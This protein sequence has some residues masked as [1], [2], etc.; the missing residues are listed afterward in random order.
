MGICK[1]VSTYSSHHEWV[2][3]IFSLIAVALLFGTVWATL[4]YYEEISQWLAIDALVHTSAL[5]AALVMDVLL[6]MAMLAV[7]SARAGEE[8]ENCFATFRGRRGG[9][10]PLDALRNWLLHMENVGRKHR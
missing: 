6:I 3:N 4:Q 8:P 9:G 1:R 2:G 10:S 5:V 7:G